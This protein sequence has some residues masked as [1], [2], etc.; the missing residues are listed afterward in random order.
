MTAPL[1]RT[2]GLEGFQLLCFRN[3][4]PL[5]FKFTYCRYSASFVPKNGIPCKEYGLQFEVDFDLA[6]IP[7]TSNVLQ[8]IISHDA[9]GAINELKTLD[10]LLSRKFLPSFPNFKYLIS[11]EII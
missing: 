7:A 8:K 11:N 1:M 4:I 3:L 2:E 5:N 10:W 9:E 6:T